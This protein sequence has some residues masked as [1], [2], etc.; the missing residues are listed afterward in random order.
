MK[1]ILNILLVMISLILMHCGKDEDQA[2]NNLRLIESFKIDVPEPSG[3]DFNFDKSGLWTVSDRNDKVYQLDLEGHITNS[4]EADG[5]DLEGISTVSNNYI[6]VVTEGNREV[7]L[8]NNSG[9]EKLKQTLNI[10]GD[11]D[12]GL[13]G[14]AYDPD[15][16]YFYAANE[17]SPKVIIKLDSTLSEVGR[18]DINFANDLSGL[19]VEGEFLWVLSDE[20]KSITKCNLNCEPIESWKLDVDSPE[21]VAVNQ[22]SGKIYV[23]SDPN[24]RL[25]VFQL[26]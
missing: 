7:I 4:F 13:E 17:K 10:N 9:K 22:S 24:S 2:E 12:S 3:L 18:Y 19:Y 15:S 5:K 11:E 25:Y 21:G 14:L 26:P 16:K 6:A 1:Q 23:V 8:L 20:S